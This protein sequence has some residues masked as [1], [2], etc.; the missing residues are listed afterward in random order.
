MKDTSAAD[1]TPGKITA[2]TVIAAFITGIAGV[3]DA[4]FRQGDFFYISGGFNVK[5][6]CCP[7]RVP[8]LPRAVRE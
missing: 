7:F 1:F 4:L 8:S 5:T 3:A 6:P 2:R